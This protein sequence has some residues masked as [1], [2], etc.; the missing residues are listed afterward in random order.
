M[1][2]AYNVPARNE[3]AHARPRPDRH[4]LTHREAAVS[5]RRHAPSGSSGLLTIAEVLAELQVARSTFD[6]WRNLGRAPECIKLPNGQI[7]VRR[8]VL[9]SWLASRSDKEAI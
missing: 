6:T 2:S 3:A 5:Q 1:S 8:C 9:D 4:R 7:R